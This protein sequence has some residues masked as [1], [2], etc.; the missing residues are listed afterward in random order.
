LTQMICNLP[1]PLAVFIYGLHKGLQ[2]ANHWRNYSRKGLEENCISRVSRIFDSIFLR[3]FLICTALVNANHPQK[4]DAD[5][6]RCNATWRGAQGRCQ[7]Q[8]LCNV[9]G[10]I[11]YYASRLGALARLPISL[12]IDLH[13]YHAQISYQFQRMAR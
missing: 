10:Q 1:C 8:D 11:P 4:N 9:Q 6:L 7:M 13:F 12:T 5:Q 2:L 3:S